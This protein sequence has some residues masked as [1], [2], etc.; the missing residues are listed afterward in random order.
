MKRFFGCWFGGVI[1]LGMVLAGCQSRTMES[2]A[3]PASPE[4][5]TWM[6]VELNGTA[7]APVDNPRHPTLRLDPAAQRVSGH[8]GVNSYGGGYEL[9]GPALRFGQLM[10]T[11]MAGPAE[12]MEL[13][14]DY[15][16]MLR[17]VTGWRLTAA[18]LELLARNR[19]VAR[20]R[21]TAGE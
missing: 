1:V 20:Y 14:R 11:M 17:G 5:I 10:S 21:S 12:L 13:E 19:T 3:V 18:G 2:A 9:N 16:A 4:G 7:V 8:A 6:L 15:T